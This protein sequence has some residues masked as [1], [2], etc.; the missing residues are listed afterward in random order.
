MASGWDKES[1]RHTMAK[2]FGKA[3]PYRDK[4]SSKITTPKR[5]GVIIEQPKQVGKQDSFFYNDTIASIKAKDGTEFWVSAT[6]DIR[7][8]I[9]EDEYRNQKGAYEATNE[10]KLTDKK[11]KEL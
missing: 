8:L 9:G 10:H 3:P 7:I 11:L 4:K 5:S 6:G 2:K 1:A